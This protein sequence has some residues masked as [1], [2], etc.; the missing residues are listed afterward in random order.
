MKPLVHSKELS[1]LPERAPWNKTQEQ[2][3]SCAWV[4]MPIIFKQIPYKLTTGILK[5]VK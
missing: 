1:L 4:L 2:N 5:V 3:H